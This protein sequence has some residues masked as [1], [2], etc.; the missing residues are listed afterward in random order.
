[1]PFCFCSFIYFSLE[2][3]LQS[4]LERSISPLADYFCSKEPL[5]H[6]TAVVRSIYTTIKRKKRR[7]IHKT[8]TLTTELHERH[9][10]RG[11]GRTR[12]QGLT[13]FWSR[14]FYQKQ[15]QK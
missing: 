4:G 9:L 14:L 2:L 10:A 6:Y 3:P 7:P 12:D 1:M 8:L 5:L 11:E 15:A 13:S